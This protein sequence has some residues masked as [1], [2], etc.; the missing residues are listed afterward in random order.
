[1]VQQSRY[2]K[3]RRIIVTVVI[4]ALAVTAT[5]MAYSTWKSFQ[6]HSTPRIVNRVLLNGTI[7][8]SPYSYYIQFSIP[9][10]AFS[11]SIHVTG[12]FSVVKGD[13]IRVY[14]M[15]ETIYNNL[16]F[17]WNFLPNYDSGWAASGEIDVRLPNGGLYYLLYDNDP[18]GETEKIVTTYVELEY[19][20]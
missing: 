14:V 3:I 19:Y 9:S 1:M 8:V 17:D 2:P 15:N 10:N 16:K 18:F 11:N 12:N 7:T 13:T 5:I 4:I 6:P 20:Y